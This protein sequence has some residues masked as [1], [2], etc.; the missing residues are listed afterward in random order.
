MSDTLEQTIIVKWE[1]I[2]GVEHVFCPYIKSYTEEVSCEI[3]QYGF[4]GNYYL[5]QTLCGYNTLAETK[6]DT[7]NVKSSQIGIDIQ[8]G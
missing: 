5:R 1:L 7:D 6:I 4:L 3:C 2:D 8:D